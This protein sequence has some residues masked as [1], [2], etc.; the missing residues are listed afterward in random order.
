M[1]GYNLVWAQTCV[2][3][4]VSGHKR[5]W[6]QSCLGTNVSGHKR[7]WAQSCLGTI[8][9]GHNCVW[10]QSCLGT[11]VFGHNRVWAQSCGYNRVGSSMYGHNRVVS[12]FSSSMLFISWNVFL[13]FVK[14]RNV[15]YA[16]RSN[17]TNWSHIFSV[18]C[19]LSKRLFSIVC[20]K[21]AVLIKNTNGIAFTNC[22][23]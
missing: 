21:R 10:A 1:C 15:D 7:V 5:V 12:T 19:V 23:C 2:G 13:T 8:V 6:A 17:N 9:Y 16:K 20:L 11:I 14:L 3:T 18:A 22:N 4:I